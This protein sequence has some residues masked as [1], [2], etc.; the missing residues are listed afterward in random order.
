MLVKNKSYFSIVLGIVLFVGFGW[1]LARPEVMGSKVCG[2]VS[3]AQLIAEDGSDVGNV[4]IWN[5]QNR[6]HTRFEPAKGWSI[7]EIAY[8]PGRYFAGLPIS[9]DVLTHSAFEYQRTYPTSIRATTFQT[10]MNWELGSDLHI[11]GRVVLAQYDADG[12]ETN[13]VAAWGDGKTYSEVAPYFKH[14][15]Q[16][17]SD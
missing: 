3:T 5:S 2:A 11:A 7:V 1:S 10:P 9:G 12:N 13:R 16:A 14:I 17:C 8:Q 4:L 15:V 6:L